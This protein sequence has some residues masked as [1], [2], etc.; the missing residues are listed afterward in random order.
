MLTPS[1]KPVGILAVLALSTDVRPLDLEGALRDTA[2]HIN[3][4]TFDGSTQ[5]LRTTFESPLSDLGPVKL[6]H[7]RPQP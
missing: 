2:I 3:K 5:Q 6:Q 4:S 1:M 7:L